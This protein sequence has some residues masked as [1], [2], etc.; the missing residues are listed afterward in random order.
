MNDHIDIK[1]A[2]TT[3]L[4]QWKWFALSCIICI[5]LAYVYLRYTPPQYNASAKI[6]LVDENAKSNPAGEILKDLSKISLPN[7]MEIEDEIQVLGSRT[8]IQ[9]VVQS[10]DLNKQFFNQGRIYNSE[11]Y[12]NQSAPIKINYIASDSIINNSKFS[13]RVQIVSET[14]FNFIYTPTLGDEISMKCFFGKNINSPVG[15]LVITPNTQKISNL[16]N[17][18]IIIQINPV[19]K[20]AEL[21]RKRIKL[22]LADKFSSVIDL[23]LNDYDAKKAK[24]VLDKLID[25][26]NR[27]SIEEK[28]IKSND[29]ANFIDERVDLM[30]TDL[31]KVDGKIEQFKTGNKLTDISSEAE[32]FLNQN[33]QTE[34]ELAMSQTALNMVNY[35]ENQISDDTYSRIPSNV[36]LD[37]GGINSIAS[38][39]N[40]LLNERDR[41]LKSSNEKNPIIVNLDQELNNLKNGLRQSLKNSSKTISLKIRNLENQSARMNSKIYAV[42]GQIRKSRDIEREQGIKES[43]YLYLLQKREEATISLVGNSPNARIIDNADS[44]N[45]PVS[46]NKRIIYLASIIIGC[47]IPFA[48][49]YVKEMLD[50]KIHNKEDLENIINNIPVLG[51][52]PKLNNRKGDLLVKLNDRSVLSESFRLIRTN[53]D[54]V[55]KGRSTKDYNNVIFVT[56]TIHGE[57]KSFF[58]MNMA[59]TIANTNKS[60]LLIGAD[61]RNPQIFSALKTKR[62]ETRPKIGLTEYLVDK[63]IVVGKTINEYDIND[64]KIDILLSGKIPPNPAELLMSDRL[65]ELFDSVS[66]QYDYVIVDTA[67]SMMVTDTLLISGFAGHTIYLARAGYTE[68]QILNFAKDLHS[69]K[70]LNGMMLVVN[71]V[72]QSNF[73]Y[74]AKYGYYGAP[75]KKSWFRRNKV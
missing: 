57:G 18:S 69:D 35:M 9:G 19:Y 58:S 39:Y 31:S 21:Y 49:F 44:T 41:L 20:V 22:S 43:L 63:S 74:G 36:G 30:A 28:N 8:M 61:I 62:K 16:I 14:A 40:E 73:G 65:K 7:E 32:L 55:Q 23:S 75:E 33:A 38:K 15:D 3:Y 45:I 2:I 68:K 67:P 59:L 13:F 12:P 4:K 25:D 64:I 51:E 50:T 27:I 66:E 42:P 46:P 6:M 5:C 10:L 17:Q 71:D 54:Y 60:V 37:D 34:Q 70:K 72:N 24:N 11:F 52:I 1:K 47:S 53:F 26:Y 56:S 48:F 29:I